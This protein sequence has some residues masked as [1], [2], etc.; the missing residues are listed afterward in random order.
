MCGKSFVDLD[1]PSG[2]AW[3]IY[4]VYSHRGSAVSDSSEPVQILFGTAVA[5]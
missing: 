2:S 5:A 4:S 3:A 1:V